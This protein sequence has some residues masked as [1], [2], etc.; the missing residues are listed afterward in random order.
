MYAVSR[1]Y[2][3][4]AT[5]SGWNCTPASSSAG[6][7]TVR[8]RSCGERLPQ[9]AERYARQTCRLN[10]ALTLIGF[11]LGGEAGARAAVKLGLRVSPDTLLNRIGQTA[12]RDQTETPVR[13]LGVD[14]FAFRR[15]H[16]YGTILVDLERRQPIDLLPERAAATLEQWLKKHAGIEVVSRDRSATYAEG[17]SKGTPEAI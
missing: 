9:V 15:G 14:D 5:W 17:I 3:G 4:R 1:T 10:E 16:R 13:V 2:P 11:A 12:A 8:K 6:I 7:W